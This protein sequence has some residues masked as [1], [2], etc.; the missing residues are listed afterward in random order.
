[1]NLG[2]RTKSSIATTTPLAVPTAKN[3]IRAWI[4]IGHVIGSTIFAGA[5]FFLAYFANLFKH[6]AN[7]DKDSLIIGIINSKY[8]KKAM[9]R[10]WCL[11]ICLLIQ[12]S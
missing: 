5:A 2:Q 3:I 6:G 11:F 4:E 8:S 1:M 12:I 9:P 7:N 10:S